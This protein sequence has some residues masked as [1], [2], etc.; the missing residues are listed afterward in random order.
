MVEDRN[1][2][3]SVVTG[4]WA[5]PLLRSGRPLNEVRRDAAAL[6]QREADFIDLLNERRTRARA[7]IWSLAEF[8]ERPLD[9]LQE[10]V[11]SLSGAESHLLTELPQFKPMKGLPDFLQSLRN[12]GMNPHMAGEITEEI[13]AFQ[14]GQEVT[15]FG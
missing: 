7:R 1:A 4:A 14:I 10:I 11:D 6:Q 5:L 15:R 8:L 3:I 9:P 12:A 2:N 13:A